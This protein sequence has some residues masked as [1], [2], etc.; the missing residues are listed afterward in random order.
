MQQNN[1]NL[2][3]TDNFQIIR[4]YLIDNGIP[5]HNASSLMKHYVVEIIS[6]GKDNKDMPAANRHF[7]NYYF[8][9][10]DKFDRYESE[11]KNV[12]DALRMRAYV[13]VN[14]KMYDQIL[15]D[16]AAECAV[17]SA[18]HNYGKPYSIY[19][20]CSGKYVNRKG[21]DKNCRKACAS[22]QF[23]CRFR[24]AGTALLHAVLVCLDHLLDHLTA[25]RACL[26]AGK[27]AVVTVFQVNADFRS[28]FHLELLHS[29]AG[30]G[31]HK[32]ITGLVRHCLHLLFVISGFIAR[33][34]LL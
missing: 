9:C 18:A 33:A 7:K 3:M 8:P 19:K 23:L 28:G 22:L 4:Q 17:R 5:Q 15:M 32:M 25:N 12:C 1:Y 31:V 34:Y 11:I 20:H 27:V 21:R 29:V 24:Q 26:T 16:T 13:S 6:R 30:C 2:N 14:Y 10:I